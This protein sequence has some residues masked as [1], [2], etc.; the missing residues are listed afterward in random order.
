MVACGAGSG[1]HVAARELSAWTTARWRSVDL[2][3]VSEL[4]QVELPAGSMADLQF[5]YPP[6]TVVVHAIPLVCGPSAAQGPQATRNTDFE[7]VPTAVE[8]R[9]RSRC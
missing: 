5:H 4:Q 2:V 9:W 7:D 1:R 6:M 8:V 3:V